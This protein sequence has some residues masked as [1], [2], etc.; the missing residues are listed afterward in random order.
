MLV[1]SRIGFTPLDDIS[2]KEKEMSKKQEKPVV[3]ENP[4]LPDGFSPKAWRYWVPNGLTVLSC[5]TGLSS[6][7]WALDGNYPVVVACILVA[8]ILDTLDGPA[9]RALGG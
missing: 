6:V 8:G 9:A 1:L 7:K 2:V 4:L 3:E 5:V